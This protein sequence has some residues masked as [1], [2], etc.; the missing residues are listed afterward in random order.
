M[1]A[2]K[3]GR[4]ESYVIEQLVFGNSVIRF[5]RSCKTPLE[6]AMEKVFDSY[7]PATK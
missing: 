2:K 6:T 3:D 5:W 4:S 1:V 7:G